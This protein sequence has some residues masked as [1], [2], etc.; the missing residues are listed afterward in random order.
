MGY[1]DGFLAPVPDANKDAYRAMADKAAVVFLDHGATRVLE[2]W[3]DDVPDGKVTDYKRAVLSE[4]GETTVFSW[5][6]WPSK[7]A[8]VAGWEKIMADERMKNDPNNQPFDGKR[9]IYADSRRS[10][11]PDIPPFP[12]EG[13]RTSR[14]IREPPPPEGERR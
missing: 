14:Q 4:P 2:G 8:R 11:T 12:G 5:V 3:G 1:A 7:A 13:H 10:S 6:E 9:M